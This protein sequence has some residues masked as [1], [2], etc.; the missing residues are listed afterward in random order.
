[1][2]PIQ[3]PLAIVSI[4]IHE[5]HILIQL[6]LDVFGHA[7]LRQG[8][9]IG[10]LVDL[11]E[12]GLCPFLG[13]FESFDHVFRR[14]V[15]RS[16][17]DVL[18]QDL[19]PFHDHGF[20]K[21]ARV[22]CGVEKG[23]RCGRREGHCH[24]VGGRRLLV[25]KQRGFEVR[26]EEAWHEEGRRNARRPDVYLDGGFGVEMVNVLVRALGDFVDVEKSGEDEMLDILFLDS[27]R[28]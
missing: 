14:V 23:Y 24:G 5:C 1:M 16:T 27:S 28:T 12:L 11:N 3:A 18:A 15:G 6:F 19:L 20:D 7:R 17:Q 9:H 21:F 26:H 13:L 10:I 8:A 22:I 25:R 2:G 4:F